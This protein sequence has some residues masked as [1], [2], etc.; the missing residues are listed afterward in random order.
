MYRLTP[1]Q[2]EVLEALVKLYEQ[3]RRLIKSV[4]I[5]EH[6]KKDEGTVR[7]VISSLKSLGLLESKTGPSGGYMPTLKAME[8]LRM[9]PVISHGVLRLWKGDRETGVIA[10]ALEIVDLLNPEGGKAIVRIGGNVEEISEGDGIRIGPTPYLRLVIEG[11]VHTIDRV[12]GQMLVRVTRMVSI[13]REPVITVSSRRLITV[14]PK[15]PLKDVAE[16]LIR[17]RIRGAPVI[18]DGR[19]VGII[20]TT[21]IA[22]A[23]SEG[24]LNALVED[25][26]KRNVVTVREDEDILDAVRLMDLYGV[27]RLVVVSATGEPVGIVTRTDILRRLSA[28]GRGRVE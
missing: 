10:F 11:V 27:G 28:L 18:S 14:S 8:L 21:D 22:R 17:N 4:E 15:D 3:H 12:L 5:A 7:N 20:T 25:Y 26:M 24:R 2:R 1:T 19:I 9:P 6:I 13:P 23:F 16:L